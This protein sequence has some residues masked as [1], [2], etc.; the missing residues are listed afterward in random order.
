MQNQILSLHQLKDFSI[1]SLSFRPLNQI[2]CAKKK[3]VEKVGTRWIEWQPQMREESTIKAF[4]IFYN[5]IF[6]NEMIKEYIVVFE[7]SKKTKKYLLK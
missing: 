3:T 6:P 2:V 1:E 4:P 7:V 5:I